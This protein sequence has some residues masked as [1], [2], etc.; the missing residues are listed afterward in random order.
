MAT[1]PIATIFQLYGVST[2]TAR[3]IIIADMM[4][5]PEGLK[6]LNVETSK[7]ISGTFKDYARREKEYENI[8][9]TK[10]QKRRLISLMSWVK[11]KTRL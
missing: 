8:I 4:S 7:E 10:V 9:F 3:N 11:D 5:Q 6:H 2:T 1:I